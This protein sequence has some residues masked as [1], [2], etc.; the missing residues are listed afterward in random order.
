MNPLPAPSTRHRR[1]L[2]SGVGVLLD[3]AERAIGHG[4][5]AAAG[6][7]ARQAVL[8]SPGRGRGWFV[9]GRLA[10]AAGD[11]GLA[12]E[13][14]AR[15]AELCP[16]RPGFRLAAGLAAVDARPREA[17]DHFRAAVGLSPSWVR[18]RVALACALSTLG[19]D[20]DAA[21]WADALLPEEPGELA[22]LSADDWA[23]LAAA[24]PEAEPVDAA[25]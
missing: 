7:L 20:E 14:L 9:L 15:A 19:C 12:L 10:S 24:R 18:A 22:S 13:H 8:L 2:A 23:E 21:Y 5:P 6:K 1:S 16:R 17:V 11:P 4:H 3:T 25:A